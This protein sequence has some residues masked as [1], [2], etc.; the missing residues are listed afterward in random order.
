MQV[1]DTEVALGDL[2]YKDVITT[3]CRGVKKNAG[4]IDVDEDYLE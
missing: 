4:V 2:S 3:E 1:M